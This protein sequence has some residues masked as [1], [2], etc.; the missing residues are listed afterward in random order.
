MLPNFPPLA[1]SLIS[2]QLHHQKEKKKASLQTNQAILYAASREHFV[3]IALLSCLSGKKRKRKIFFFLHL[4]YSILFYSITQ[5]TK[6]DRGKWVG[7]FSGAGGYTFIYTSEETKPG[8]L[9]LKR[10]KRRCGRIQVFKIM[11]SLSIGVV[12]G[13]NNW[14]V[15][16]KN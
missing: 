13:I 10:C 1:L 16:G 5:R 15:Q 7:G 11:F 2:G 8:V 9:I 6:V 4:F 12:I 3:K 14:G